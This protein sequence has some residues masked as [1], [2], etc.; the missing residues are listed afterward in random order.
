MGQ[1]NI[2]KL[3]NE[4]NLNFSNLLE[5]FDLNGKNVVKEIFCGNRFAKVLTNFHSG[6]Y[7]IHIKNDKKHY[8]GKINVD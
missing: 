2:I 6:I 3:L 8:V 5:I 7:F 4:I 1:S